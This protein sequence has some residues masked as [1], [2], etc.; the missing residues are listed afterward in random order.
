MLEFTIL[1][2]ARALRELVTR[3]VNTVLSLV[4]WD[5]QELAILAFVASID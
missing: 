4:L 3:L 5:M 1:A 2:P